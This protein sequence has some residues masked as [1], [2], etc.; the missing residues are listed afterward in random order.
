MKGG[1][2]EGDK[3][4]MAMVHISPGTS[5]AGDVCKENHR[6]VIV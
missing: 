4:K 6:D 5:E 2:I 3:V 1:W